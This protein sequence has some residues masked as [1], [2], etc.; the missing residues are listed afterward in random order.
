MEY[1]IEEILYSD[2][3]KEK[4]NIYDYN[5]QEL[6][7]LMRI[8]NPRIHGVEEKAEIQMKGTGKLFN[9]IIE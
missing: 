6:W 3:S 5:I 7:K 9:E 4:M 2:N 1:K 8:P